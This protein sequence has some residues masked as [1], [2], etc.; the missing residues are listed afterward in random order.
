MSPYVKPLDMC[1]SYGQ[2]MGGRRCTST[3][4]APKWLDLSNLTTVRVR[5]LRVALK[6]RSRQL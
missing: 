5:S 3:A 4:S 2:H 6:Q 1:Q